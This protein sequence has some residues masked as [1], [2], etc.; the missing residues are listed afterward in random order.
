MVLGHCDMERNWG[1]IQRHYYEYGP[2]R[3]ST[4]TLCFWEC[5][6]ES[7]DLILNIRRFLLFLPPELVKNETEP[8][9]PL[10]E[11]FTGLGDYDQS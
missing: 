3:V 9:A 6:Q 2:E 7:L 4:V 10:E 11:A 8:L 1:K 5:I